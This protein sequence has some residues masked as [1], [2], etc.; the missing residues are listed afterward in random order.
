MT[1]QSKANQVDQLPGRLLRIDDIADRLS[2]SR[3]M[4]WKLVAYGHIKAL[5]L[6]RAVR[7]RPADLEDYLARAARES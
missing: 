3:S 4:A 2:I 6:G 1:P 7:V 5:R